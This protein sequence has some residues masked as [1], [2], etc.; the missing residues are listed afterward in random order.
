M[1]CQCP[2]K[3]MQVRRFIVGDNAVKIKNNGAQQGLLSV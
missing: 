3:A 2:L 1:L